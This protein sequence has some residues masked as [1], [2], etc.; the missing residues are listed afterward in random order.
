MTNDDKIV[1]S[2]AE[3]KKEL[4][5]EAYHVMREAGTE[6]PF[7]GKFDAFF[8]DGMYKCG[9]CGS[10]LFD[11]KTKYDSGCGW[12][13]FFAPFDAKTIDLI[14]DDTL[15]MHRIEVRCHH[16]GAHLGHVFDDGPEPTGKRFCI[17]SASLKF[18]PVGKKPMIPGV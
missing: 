10:T 11:S 7:T 1:K 15:G 2:D 12:P 6:A 18:E 14:N 9:S 17:N 5:P 16:C 13:A 4:S 3:W 8:E